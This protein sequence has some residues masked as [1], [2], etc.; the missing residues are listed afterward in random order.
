MDD[1]Q[2]EAIVTLISAMIEQ[3]II[4]YHEDGTYASVADQLVEKAIRALK[5]AGRP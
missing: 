1:A 3:H 5:D 2:V 4:E